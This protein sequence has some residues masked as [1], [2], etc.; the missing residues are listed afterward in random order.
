MSNEETW[1][2]KKLEGEARAAEETAVVPKKRPPPPAR[3]DPKEIRAR[4]LLTILTEDH[5]FDIIKEMVKTYQEVQTLQNDMD[6]IKLSLSI[7]RE[8][9]KY[10]F[11]AIR[12]DDS[13][14]E[15]PGVIFNISLGGDQDPVLKNITPKNIEGG[16]IAVSHR[17]VDVDE[18]DEEWR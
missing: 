7:Q 5:N 9:L 4:R 16:S 10:C 14:G 15:K 18:D 6:R 8:L 3:K 2:I 11:P 17:G 13:G 12:P 1:S